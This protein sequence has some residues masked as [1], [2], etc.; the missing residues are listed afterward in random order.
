LL[1]FC[2]PFAALL[3][4]FFEATSCYRFS[5]QVVAGLPYL[6]EDELFSVAF[7]CLSLPILASAIFIAMAPGTSLFRTAQPRKLCV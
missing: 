4:P 1:P 7:D 2:C 3:L 6:K 5:Y